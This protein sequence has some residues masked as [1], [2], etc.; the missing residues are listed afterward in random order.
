MVRVSNIPALKLYRKLG[1]DIVDTWRAYYGDG[2]NA[3]L[4]E[5]QAN[6]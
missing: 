2:E 6:Q 1:Y 4:M 5:K 3:Y